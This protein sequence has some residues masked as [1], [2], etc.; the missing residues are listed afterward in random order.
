MLLPPNLRFLKLPDPLS[1]GSSTSVAKRILDLVIDQK[2]LLTRLKL[3]SCHLEKLK[4]VPSSSLKQLKLLELDHGWNS[5]VPYVVHPDLQDLLPRCTSLEMFVVHDNA[6]NFDPLFDSLPASLSKL[7]LG[8]SPFDADRLVHYIA[9]CD[10]NLK[11]IELDRIGSSSNLHRQYREDEETWAHRRWNEKKEE[12]VEIAC[13]SR[14]IECYWKGDCTESGQ[15]T[16]TMSWK[17]RVEV[18]EETEETG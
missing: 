3:Y 11:R 15:R 12:D 7:D 18:E 4:F 2:P 13:D 9:N 8:R 16:W 1:S 10:P 14:S 6:L 17:E 5:M